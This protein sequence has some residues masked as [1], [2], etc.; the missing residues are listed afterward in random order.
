MHLAVFAAPSQPIL[1]P[2]IGSFSMVSR[3]SKLVKLVKSMSIGAD[4]NQITDTDVSQQ[5]KNELEISIPLDTKKISG[6]G[7]AKERKKF[8]NQIFK[9]ILNRVISLSDL[10]HGK[11]Y[12]SYMSSNGFAIFSKRKWLG[13]NLY[14]FLQSPKSKKELLDNE[15][16]NSLDFTVIDFRTPN[17]YKPKNLKTVKNF[18]IVVRASMDSTAVRMK[19]VGFS[20]GVPSSDIKNILESVKDIMEH[21]VRSS[22]EISE[23]RYFQRASL[24][25]DSDKA[26]KKKRAKDLDRIINPENYKVRLVRSGKEE[27]GAAAGGRYTPSAAAQARRQVK[28]K[29]G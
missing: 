15:I 3:Q 19:I 27:A 11:N 26:E 21:R 17:I 4:K 18:R 12:K 6:F 28:K 10:K 5:M 16:K 25:I 2:H 24:K 7:S 22:I 29:G 8:L 9:Q 1:E 23:S 20:S 13:W 14:T